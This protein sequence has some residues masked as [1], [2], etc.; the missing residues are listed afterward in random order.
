MKRWQDF[1]DSLSTKGGNIFVLALCSFWLAML[2][3][4]VTHHDPSAVEDVK[5]TLAG[6]TGALLMALSGN[7][8]RQQMVD[9]TVASAPPA[10]T[11][12]KVETVNVG[13]QTVPKHEDN[14]NTDRTV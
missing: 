12:E 1:L 5:T 3:L 10:V 2:F 11:T 4:H 9:R 14:V 8:S 6:F 7:A 13:Q